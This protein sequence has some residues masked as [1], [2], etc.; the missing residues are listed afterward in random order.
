[1]MPK[2]VRGIERDDT[3]GFFVFDSRAMDIRHDA[4]VF[5]AIY[6]GLRSSSGVCAFHGGT[7]FSCETVR[8][9]AK[10]AD[11]VEPS[12]PRSPLAD[13]EGAFEF[14]AYFAAMWTDTYRN[15]G[16]LHDALVAARDLRGYLGYMTRQGKYDGDVDV[17]AEAVVQLF[18]LQLHLPANIALR[19]GAIIKGTSE[20][21]I[22]LHLANS[23]LGRAAAQGDLDNVMKAIAYGADVNCIDPMH[24]STT[25][26]VHAASNGH[27]EVVKGL[28]ANG[29]NPNASYKGGNTALIL[30]SRFGHLEVVKAL[31]AGGVDMDAHD[32]NGGTALDNASDHPNIQVVLK[33]AGARG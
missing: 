16:V 15:F 6:D 27:A 28:L 11:H 23:A 7:I 26:I 5:S 22:G 18:V 10:R 13:L 4:Q 21:G 2:P 19:D 9:I 12:S 1:M 3:C 31:I 8:E 24:G 20:Y 14:D 17:G 32:G 25:P 29:A 33:A 30:A